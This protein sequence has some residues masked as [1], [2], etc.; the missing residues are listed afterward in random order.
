TIPS[1]TIHNSAWPCSTPRTTMPARRQTSILVWLGTP[2][3]RAS[4]P[5][6]L[7]FPSSSILRVLAERTT[8]LAPARPSFAVVGESTAPSIPSSRA[9]TPILPEPPLALWRG[10]TVDLTVPTALPGSRSTNTLLLPYWANPS[11]KA[12]HSRLTTRITTKRLWS[13]LIASPLTN[14]CPTSSRQKSPMSGTKG[15]SSTRRRTL[16]PSPSAPSIP[17]LHPHVQPD[18]TSRT[19]NANRFT[20]P[21]RF[22]RAS[23]RSVPSLNRVLTPY[24]RASFATR[25]G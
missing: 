15:N 7:R 18:S 17:P 6:G 3:I 24:R 25:A 1:R 11:C 4:R 21:T 19:R 12:P 9:T 13:T 2:L 5:R 22:T 8:C 16:T 10:A 14:L 23:R 20:P